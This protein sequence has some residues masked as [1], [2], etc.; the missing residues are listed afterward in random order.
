ME[1]VKGGEA[2][3]TD[4]TVAFWTCH[5]SLTRNLGLRFDGKS[6]SDGVV[7]EQSVCLHF[8]LA[9]RLTTRC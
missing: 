4:T 7:I 5:D 6:Y 9:P 3:E 2:K 8:S 1:V